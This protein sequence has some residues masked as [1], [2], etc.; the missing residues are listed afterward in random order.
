MQGDQRQPRQQPATHARA[1]KQRGGCNESAVVG[2]G[3]QHRRPAHQRDR[4]DHAG[5]VA[6]AI[7]HHA[8]RQ[9]HG[10]AA[11]PAHGIDERG[12]RWAAAELKYVERHHD[13]ERRLGDS[14]QAGRE[15]DGPCEE[16]ERGACRLGQNC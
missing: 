10:D 2:R 5:P 4:A 12:E 1:K 14:H 15:I 11:E 6:V 8:R 7:D 13:Q 9:V 3:D 16:P